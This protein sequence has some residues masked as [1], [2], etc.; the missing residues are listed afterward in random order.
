M[1]LPKSTEPASMVRAPEDVSAALP[2]MLPKYQLP[3]ADTAAD[4]ER[5]RSPSSVEVLPISA[6]VIVPVPEVRDRS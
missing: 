3:A 6:S 1:I 4:V 5:A 2:V